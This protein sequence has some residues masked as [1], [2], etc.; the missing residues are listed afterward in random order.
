MRNEPGIGVRSVLS[1][2]CTF[3]NHPTTGCLPRVPPA[4]RYEAWRDVALRKTAGTGRMGT[5]TVQDRQITP[6]TA[7]T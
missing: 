1:S 7:A 3:I 5:L 6:L 4:S 2:R